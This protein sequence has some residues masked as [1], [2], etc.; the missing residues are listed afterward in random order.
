MTS[1][2]RHNDKTS[3][4]PHIGDRKSLLC[5]YDVIFS[6]ITWNFAPGLLVFAHTK[7]GSFQIKESGV[8]RG[9]DSAS[10]PPRP[11]G[12]FK[13]PAWIGLSQ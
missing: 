9:A 7:F 11:E 1:F 8:K 6:Q 2:W 10:P 5:H 13:I 12:V 3:K 4:Y